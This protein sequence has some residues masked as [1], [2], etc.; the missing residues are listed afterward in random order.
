MTTIDRLRRDADEEIILGHPYNPQ[1]IE[2]IIMENRWPNVRCKVCGGM[3]FA[4]IRK[5]MN[6][7]QGG[8]F[9]FVDPECPNAP[10][11]KR[12]E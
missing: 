11:E 4:A 2:D 3:H 9:E 6:T 1:Q 10:A 8:E 7:L 12:E 5:I